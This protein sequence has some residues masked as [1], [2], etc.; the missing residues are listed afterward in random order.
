MKN[1]RFTTV[2]S[3]G[4]LRV[5]EIIVD[6]ETGVHYLCNGVLF[7]YTMTPLLDKEGKPI[8]IKDLKEVLYKLKK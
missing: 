1:K 5:I 2:Y 3:Q 8:V 7:F 4:V 6:R